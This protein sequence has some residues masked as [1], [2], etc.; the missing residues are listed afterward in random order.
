MKIDN[1]TLLNMT[2]SLLSLIDNILSTNYEI[3]NDKTLN[4]NAINFLKTTIFDNN[5]L[6]F[7]QTFNQETNNQL[8]NAPKMNKRMSVTFGGDLQKNLVKIVSKKNMNIMKNAGRRCSMIITETPIEQVNSTSTFVPSYR[9]TSVSIPFILPKNFN[10]TVNIN[11]NTNNLNNN[12]DNN[13]NK[14]H[15]NKINEISEIKEYSEHEDND[16]F[17]KIENNDESENNE[18]E[19]KKNEKKENENNEKQ[20]ENL[21]KDKK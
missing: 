20:N 8:I 13:D 18:K 14:N 19:E 15:D 10:N 16:G 9:R 11:K 5:N 17:K 12:N 7:G 21:K 2:K 3:A 1:K 4:A 6:N